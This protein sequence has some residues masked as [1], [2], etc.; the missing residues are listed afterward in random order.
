M[1]AI[2]AKRALIFVVAMFSVSLIV[3]CSGMEK[4][5]VN[6]SGYLYYPTALVN[7]DRALDEAR[8]AGKDRECPT[9]FNASKDMVDRAY[10]IYMAC[11]TDEAIAM[12]NEAT[13][14][15]KALCPRAGKVIDRLTIRVNFDFDKSDI[16]KTDEAELKKAI[17]FVS[18]YSHAKVELE[19]HTDGKGTEEYNQK[20]S[21]RR[22]EAVRQYLIKEGAVGKARISARGYGKTKPIAPN[23]TKDGKDN[24]EGRA[25]NRRVEILIISK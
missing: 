5:P 6:R 7:A 13:A 16:R 23:T 3:G 21:E 17:D 1:Q 20:L 4:R 2:T 24:P 18:K 8:S 11:R 14:K 22:A 9:E 15:I 12:A 25:E 10:E 19:G